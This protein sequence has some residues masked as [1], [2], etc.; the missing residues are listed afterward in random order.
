MG[1]PVAGALDGF[2]SKGLFYGP[3]LHAST[4]AC[5]SGRVGT[6]SPGFATPEYVAAAAALLDGLEAFADPNPI[7]L[8]RRHRV[9]LG[10]GKIRVASSVIGQE[11]TDPF[12]PVRGLV[13]EWSADSRLNMVERMTSVDW[14][15][16]VAP[17]LPGWRPG[18]LTL[19]MPADWERLAPTGRAFKRL[20]RRFWER[21]AR[22]WGP[23]MCVWKL[24]FQQ[25]GAPHLHIYTALPPGREFMEWLSVAWTAAVHGIARLSRGTKPWAEFIAAA[26][27]RHGQGVAD[28]LQAGTG[29]DWAE[30]IRASDPKRLAIYFLKRATGHNLGTNKEY[31][32]TVPALWLMTGGAGR[33]WGIKGLQACEVEVLV[34]EVDFVWLRR[35]MRRWAKANK[36]PVKALAGGIG[37]GGMVLANDA[38]GLLA[39]AARWLT[40]R[41][42]VA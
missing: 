15:P 13:T 27:A 19:T 10:P 32:H 14:G 9:V 38:P 12:A 40:M 34:D 1:A 2:A 31:Q 20:V 36:R 6:A 37:Q 21:W 23:V 35:V 18:M 28:H 5:E 29:V 3:Y 8:A 33:F 30:G 22:K 42:A 24:E 11:T 41:K 16:V 25:R 7:G 17:A 39:Q 26:A 4:R